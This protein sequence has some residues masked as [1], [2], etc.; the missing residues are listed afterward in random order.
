MGLNDILNTARDAL[1]AQQYALGVTGQNIANVNTPGYARRE[2]LLSSEPLGPNGGTVKV[3]GV[4][5]VVDQFTEKRLYSSTG[6]SSGASQHSTD[7]GTIES[8]FNESQGTGIATSLQAMF[9]SF[10]SLGSNP[11]DPT[12]R[13]TVLAK[14]DAFAQSVSSTANNLAQFQTDELNAAKDVVSQINT[15]ASAIADLSSKIANAQA[16]SQD[17]ADLI[18]QRSQLITDLSGLVDV[19]TFTDGQ[20]QL[21]IQSSGTTLVE[22]G[23]ARS[24]AIGVA[25]DGSMQVLA[26]EPGGASNDV[27]QYLSGGKLAGIRE[28]RDVD[29]TAVMGQLDQLAFDVANAVNTQHALGYGQDGASGRNLFTVGTTVAGSARGL[30]VDP[31][32]VGHPEFV[33]ASGNPSGAAGDSSNATALAELAD[34]N[35]TSGGTRTAVQAYSDIV[36]DVGLRKQAADTDSQTRDA[37]KAQ[38]SQMRDSTSGVNLDEEMVNLT[39]FQ[40]AYQAASKVLTTADQMLGDLMTSV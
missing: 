10:S 40:T 3:D 15:K 13:S 16:Q 28:A 7:L 6:L 37:M 18:D 11:T 25:S 32:M 9:D 27:T 39:K 38:V 23:T 26:T 34:S 35:L 8:L 30:A 21:V 4:R 24:L 12:A 5:Q 29:A 31:G 36:G 14:A 22:G 19:N 2:A 20:G 33:A 17:A 1:G